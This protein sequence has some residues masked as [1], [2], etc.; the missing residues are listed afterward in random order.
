[1]ESFWD[2]LWY[3]IIVFA[4]VAYL[5]VFFQIL[6]DLF[7]D[8]TVSGVGKALWVIALILIPFFSALV[9]LVVR[10]HGMAIRTGHAHLE[11]RQATDRYIR[12]VAGK[13]A[14]EQISE[15]KALYDSGA[16]TA[17]EFEQLKARA[18]GQSPTGPDDTPVP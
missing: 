2:F 4:F 12:Q 17:A 14:A 7:R 6:T 3:T 9:Y 10:G 1:M 11:A 5:I 13:S 16:I 8:R 18:V 15:A